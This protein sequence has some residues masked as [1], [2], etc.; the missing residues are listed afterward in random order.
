MLRQKKSWKS[1]E[2]IT[3]MK[4]KRIGN[5]AHGRRRRIGKKLVFL[6]GFCWIFVA[7]K[8]SIFGFDLKEY[9]LIAIFIVGALIG[10]I[11][12]LMEKEKSRG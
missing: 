4:G 1:Y 8:A 12:L 3:F 2:E 10:I 6:G 11:G 7:A 9:W 5:A